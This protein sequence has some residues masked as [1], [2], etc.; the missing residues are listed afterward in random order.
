MASYFCEVVV[1]NCR[2]A[3][4]EVREFSFESGKFE[5]GVERGL[6]HLML[7]RFTDHYKQPNNKRRQKIYKMY[8]QRF[9]T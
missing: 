8:E 5:I 3:K 4:W 2:D 1:R 9:A 6:L 7:A